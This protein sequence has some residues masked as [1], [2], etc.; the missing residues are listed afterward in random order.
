MAVGWKGVMRT[1]SLPYLLHLKLE[2]IIFSPRNEDKQEEWMFLLIMAK[3]SQFIVL[4]FGSGLWFCTIL[5][6]RPLCYCVH[7]L[8]SLMETLKHF[9]LSFIFIP[10]PLYEAER[11]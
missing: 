1:N 10:F 4:H 7:L 9:L 5:S 3:T 11:I 6:E 8:W 2:K